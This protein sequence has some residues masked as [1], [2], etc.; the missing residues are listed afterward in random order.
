[1]LLYVEQSLLREHAGVVM[2]GPLLVHTVLNV[3]FVWSSVFYDTN[4][5]RGL[6]VYRGEVVNSILGRYATSKHNT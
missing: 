3:P 2:T 6:R 1:M 4:A 5:L